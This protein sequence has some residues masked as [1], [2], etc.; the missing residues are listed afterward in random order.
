MFLSIPAKVNPEHEVFVLFT[1][2]VGFKDQAPSSL[3]NALLS[4]PNINFNYLNLT[5]YAKDT[6]LEDWIKTGKLTLF[7]MLGDCA[8]IV[9]VGFS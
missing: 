7:L 6:P 9:F 5:D 3:F 4:Y 8:E 1:S 2:P